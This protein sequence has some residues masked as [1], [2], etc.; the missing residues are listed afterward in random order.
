MVKHVF[1]MFL[2]L[3]LLPF[4]VA[5]QHVVTGHIKDAGMD[6]P[7]AGVNIV[8]K[9]NTSIG[10]ISD[11]DGNFSLNVPEASVLVFTYIGYVMQ[12][13]N[14]GS[15]T[16]IQVVM[17]ED[18]QLLDE[19]VVVGYGSQKKVNLTGA[20]SSVKMEE[21]TG[22]RPINSIANALQ[23]N[24]PGLVLS[25]NSG[26][27]GSGFDFQIRGMSSING[28]SPLILV[29]NVAI[30]ISTIN[31]EDIESVSVL[32]DASA[33]AI[34]GA[35]AAFGVILVTTKKSEKDKKNTFTYSTKMTFTNPQSLPKQATPLQSIQAL[36]D[37]G[38][39][40]SNGGQSY[41]V[42]KEQLQLYAA[43]PGNYPD[44]Y[45]VIDDYRYQLAGT[46]LMED[47]MS[48]GFQQ[49][50]DISVSGGSSKSTYRI[51]AGILDQDGV[52]VTNKDKYSRYNISSFI[53]T[54]VSSWFTAQLT[55]L[56]SHSKKKDP[57]T[58]KIN[59]RDVW[60]QAVTLPSYYPTGGMTINDEYYSFA[61]PA[62]MMDRVV[63]DETNIDRLNLLGRIILKP[64]E[65]MT[66]TGEYA[67]NKDFNSNR[68]YNKRI[69]DL[70]DGRT[71]QISPADNVSSAYRM[72]KSN[73][74][75]NAANVFAA[76]NKRIQDHDFT[77]MAGMNA[78]KNNYE[79]IWVRRD[80]MINDELPSIGQS[81]G[82]I[83]S[84]D[85]FIEN[86]IFGTFYRVNY[87]YKDRYLFEA[88]GRYDGSS[89][90]PED[91]RFGFF[92]S[93]S[94][95]W[96]ISE[97]A[98]MQ[99]IRPT[100]SNLKLRASWGSIGNQ[101]IDTYSYFAA[102]NSAN[103]S[104]GLN[105]EK[106]ITL[107]SPILVRSNFTWEE[108]R[109]INGGLDFGFLNNRLNGTFDIF[110]RQTLNMLGPGADYPSVLGANAPMQNA[111]DMETNGWEFQISWR[112]Q[113]GEVSYG[114]G[115]NISDAQSKITKFKNDTKSLA[116]RYDADGKELP[117]YYDGAKI[118]EI[119]GYETDRL[120]TVDDFVEGTLQT[121]AAGVL[122][123]G[124]LKE[125][126][127]RMKGVSPNPGDVLFKHPDEEGYIWNSLN[128]V[129]DPGSRRVIGNTTPRYTYGIS[130]DISW[131]GFGLY[132]LLQ[133]VGKRD[134]WYGNNLAF[135]YRSGF[136]L[137]LYS[138]QLDYWIPENPQ[139]HY[140]RL[141]PLS[142]YNYGTNYSV[143]D[144]YLYNAAYLD[145]RSVTLSYDLPRTT[146]SKWGFE[147]ISVFVNGENLLTFNHMPKGMHP[148]SK[149]RGAATGVS[150]G[151]ATYPVMRMITGGINVTF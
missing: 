147:R 115:F 117:A 27:P 148:D 24:V 106:P 120:Y 102:M 33:A 58:L 91:N 110:R 85:N 67:I 126:V 103:A 5:A 71:Y 12:E 109:T 89:K 122:T 73:T 43:N 141:Y 39:T 30:D 130:G 94:A 129:D 65:G 40:V 118:G 80:H 134:Q 127:P 131:R 133:G 23:G 48:T 62:N 42:W 93:F 86:A 61:T 145:L 11:M 15:Q 56:Y 68:I 143:Q 7:L 136:D 69:T 105:G 45:T 32:K 84:S 64:F 112:D 135:P 96:R 2:V 108:V 25:N 70:A 114:L 150:Q 76:Y 81:V 138:H 1:S 72:Q 35:R 16:S 41:S 107:T 53:S 57:Y 20:V 142:G 119:W 8:V 139:A 63:P 6:E 77:I 66:I 123:G 144:R 132:F 36:L 140:A 113:I 92:P 82:T 100:I 98:F 29:D 18:N 99:N 55:A 26:E 51:A 14:V 38:N 13:V 22:N 95:G 46:D 87:S 47:L 3:F 21:I 111:A 49:I 104:W 83:T 75:Y 146:I 28:G 19:V 37:G 52:L 151:G 90:F 128:T 4:T 124:T 44:G 78:E 121:T 34:Y 125:G 17:V 79:E 137:A 97:E 149:V 88:S 10:T 59:S 31:P 116:P 50:H 54:D 9:G 101:N 60:S 74:D